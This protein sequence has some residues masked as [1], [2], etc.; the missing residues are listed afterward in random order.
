MIDALRTFLI[1]VTSC[2][3]LIGVGNRDHRIRVNNELRRFHATQIMPVPPEFE[4]WWDSTAAC[5][6]V[7]PKWNPQA[8]FYLADTIPPSMVAPIDA[9]KLFEGYADRDAQVVVFARN[10]NL[11][12]AI[13]THEVWHLHFGG[14]HPS[15]TFKPPRC[16]MA[17]P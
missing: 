15:S 5:L 3:A 2:L 10:S 14:G 17:S 1:V 6:G 16:G 7:K 9:S 4:I 12:R 8:R 13:V 11:D